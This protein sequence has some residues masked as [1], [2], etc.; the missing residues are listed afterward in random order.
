MV[1]SMR[2]SSST[3]GLI[4]ALLFAIFAFQLNA[5]MLSPVLATMEQ[6]LG[7]T[8]ARIGLTQTAFFTAAALFSLILPRWGDLVGRR[9]IMVAMVAVT[10]IGSIIAALS[11]NVGMLFVPMALIMLRAQMNDDK[12]YA[13]WMA[14]LASVNGGIAGVDALAGGWLASAF[15]FRSVFW[16]MAAVAVLAVVFVLMG[17]EDTRGA[18]KLP[19]D[20][21]GSAALVVSLGTV[22]TAF[23]QL[24]KLGEADFVLIAVLLV[25]GAA[26]FAA[27]WRIES[28]SSAPLVATHYLKQRRTWGLLA[29]TTLTMTGVFAIMNGLIPNLAQSQTFAGLDAGT[30]SWVTLTPYALAGLVFGPVAGRLAA[31]YG[32]VTVLRGGMIVTVGGIVFSLLVVSVPTAVTLLIV[33]VWLGIAYAGVVNIMLNGL[34]VVLSPKD[35]AGYLPGMNSGAFNIG[36]GLSYALLFAVN[37]ALASGHGE[38]AGYRGGLVTAIVVVALALAASFLI[39]S[40]ASVNKAEPAAKD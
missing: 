20:W 23:N 18:Q 34:G 7:T 24:G 25:I 9:K 39:P 28:T 35:N 31:R 14:V 6:E 40:P 26:A 8:T 32:Y 2:K 1:T 3:A 16:A 33:S 10:A 38:A 4:L 22:L 21:P 29:T 17:T 27:F 13:L 36:A 19:M 11:V 15:G 37:T 5:S 30:V 12:K